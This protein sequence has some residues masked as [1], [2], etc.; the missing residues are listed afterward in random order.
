MHRREGPRLKIDE[1][2]VP[3][4]VIDCWKGLLDKAA[5][6]EL[7]GLGKQHK[8]LWE[9]FRPGKAPAREVRHRAKVSL[10]TFP[11]LPDDFKD[12]L[13]RAG[14]TQSLLCALS[15]AALAE[16]A[17]PLADLFGR[18]EMASA[19]LLDSREPVRQLGFNLLLKWVL[20]GRKTRGPRLHEL[21]RTCAAAQAS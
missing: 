11:G 17:A 6:A 12:I 10:G 15:E 5:D 18:A 16:T 13:V 14:L 9:G 19:L 20:E 8:N 1:T 2:E 3:Q 7:A 21:R 4:A